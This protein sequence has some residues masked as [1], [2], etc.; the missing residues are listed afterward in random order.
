MAVVGSGG[1]RLAGCRWI[2]LVNVLFSFVD[3]NAIKI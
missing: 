3:M 2:G 1:Y